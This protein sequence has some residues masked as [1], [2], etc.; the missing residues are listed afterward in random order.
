MINVL[1]FRTVVAALVAFIASIA[2]AFGFDP[3]IA[4]WVENFSF[5]VLVPL[6]LRLGIFKA[7]Q[8]AKVGK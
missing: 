6:F 2:P 1:Q 4:K 3:Q 5:Y 7:E 8:A